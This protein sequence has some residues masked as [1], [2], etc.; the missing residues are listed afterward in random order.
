MAAC[1]VPVRLL[2]IAL[3]WLELAVLS[4]GRFVFYSLLPCTHG[5]RG[6]M[7]SSGFALRQL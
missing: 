4:V 6:V 7:R 3:T 5:E 1:L 2:A